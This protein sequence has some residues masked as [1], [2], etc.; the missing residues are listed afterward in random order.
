MNNVFCPNFANKK[1]KQEFEE[2][3]SIFGEDGAYLLWNQTKGNGLEL[4]PNG[5][6]SKLFKT[7]MKLFDG[8]RR[9]ALIAK[10]RVY[11]QEF[12]DWFG[13]WINDKENASKVVDKNGEPLI[14]QHG[15][16]DDKF[17]VFLPRYIRAGGGFWA[18]DTQNAEG[19]GDKR[20]YLFMNLRNPYNAEKLFDGKYGKGVYKKIL[21]Y[22]RANDRY[23]EHIRYLEDEMQGL[24]YALDF[25]P[26]SE[27]S[28]ISKQLSDLHAQRM[29]LQRPKRPNI[30]QQA[31]DDFR[32]A[33]YEAERDSQYSGLDNDPFYYRSRKTRLLHKKYGI[34]G[35]TSHGYYVVISSNQLKSATDNNGNFDPQDIDIR[36]NLNQ[37]SAENDVRNSIIEEINYYDKDSD[38]NE[39]AVHYFH[40]EGSKLYVTKGDARTL[41]EAVN[42]ATK[43]L[44]K[45]GFTENDFA[46]NSKTGE[47][48]F[49][50]TAED[51]YAKDS[52][53]TSLEARQH[54]TQIAEYLKQ[55]TGL[56]Y[57]L[58]KPSDLAKIGVN[59]SAN[60]FVKDGVVYLVDGRFTEQTTI[61]EFLHPF[62]NAI[63]RTNPELFQSLLNEA[64]Q[65]FPQLKS[66]IY[67]LYSNKK[68]F[69]TQDR[70]QE[71]V[72]QALSRVQQEEF[73]KGLGRNKLEQLIHK[74][75]N[76]IKQLFS[77]EVRA[78]D[79][80]P[81]TTLGQLARI[82]NSE[83]VSLKEDSKSDTQTRYNITP[84]QEQK[85]IVEKLRKLVHLRISA[86]RRRK[87]RDAMVEADFDMLEQQLIQL[88]DQLYNGNQA[89][90]QNAIDEIFKQVINDDKNRVALLEIAKQEVMQVKQHLD[91]IEA[92]R[93]QGNPETLLRVLRNVLDYYGN[94]M[95]AGVG[96]NTES[97]VLYDIFNSSQF[98][99]LPNYQVAL[100]EFQDIS[101][102]I[103]GI[104]GCR[105]KINSIIK[106]GI[107]EFLDKFIDQNMEAGDINLFKEN[108]HRWLDQ[109]MQTTDTAKVL[110]DP[111]SAQ[112]PVVRIFFHYIRQQQ[113]KVVDPT[114]EVMS[115]LR[116]QMDKLQSKRINITNYQRRFCET[117]SKGHTTGYFISEY[118]TGE[119]Y[120]V[121]REESKKIAQKYIDSGQAQYAIEDGKEVLQFAKWDD[122]KAYLAEVDKMKDKYGNRRYKAE[123]YIKRR[124][125][126][127]KDTMAT[128]DYL[129]S[130]INAIRSKVAEEVEFTSATGKKFKKKI[131]RL[132]KLSARDYQA[133]Q[134]L[135]Q[136]KAEFAMTYKRIVDVNG[137]TVD[138]VPKTGDELRMAQ[139][140]TKWN[141]VKS[142]NVGYRSNDDLGLQYL[143]M[144]EQQ[145][146]AQ[147]NEYKIACQRYINQ[148]QPTQDYYDELDALLDKHALPDD[149]QEKLYELSSIVKDIKKRASIKGRV[150]I[151]MSKLSENDFAVMKRVEQEISDIL[152][153]N[154]ITSLY[155]TQDPV[156]LN[157]MRNINQTP[158]VK[159]DGT[160]M[161]VKYRRPDGSEFTRT[162]S[163]FDYLTQGMTLSEIEAKYQYV[164]AK[165]RVVSL[166]VFQYSIPSD[167]NQIGD[168]IENFFAPEGNWVNDEYD[169]EW[170]ASVQPKEQFRNQDYDKLDAEEKKMLEMLKQ[171]MKEANKKYGI[172]GQVN[173]LLMPQIHAEASETIFGNGQWSN[174]KSL[175][176][177]IA[178][179]MRKKF[180]IGDETDD[181]NQKHEDP[182]R[183]K[184]GGVPVRYNQKMDDPEHISTDL[185]HTVTKYYEAASE[186]DV[187]TDA[188]NLAE[189]L[190]YC[191][192]DGRLTNIMDTELYGIKTVVDK[193]WQLTTLKQLEDWQRYNNGHLL[194][195]QFTFLRGI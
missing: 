43:H 37:R 51:R 130:K 82:I 107:D 27:S 39:K 155:H 156:A 99:N 108:T 30:P 19:Y 167:P 123:Y 169:E 42:R 91:A 1:V 46:I 177:G 173:E 62:V 131:Y 158:Y 83:G 74:F 185:L 3:V 23:D 61:E 5:A 35:E 21:E 18:E 190:N 106:Q 97:G 40:K 117:D 96:T 31:F 180:G 182:D 15:T 112:N 154:N 81:D 137:N 11:T 103:N 160:T 52:H 20:I 195:L 186:Y 121:V 175:N 143:K 9:K 187:L 55:V 58:I 45:K 183:Q 164:N 139:E 166:S 13:D 79:L 176:T 7:Y 152:V 136:R 114:Q 22:N 87:V 95:S 110:G 63:M 174:P 49:P 188:S 36:Y 32:E 119:Y 153:Q 133:L 33:F 120:R 94:A 127:S 64:A 189:L 144:C 76:A 41:Q 50:K 71:L 85:Q 28:D 124:E 172:D 193:Q 34:D 147:S 25:L 149:V 68:G 92:G 161:S 47:I 88:H 24:N 101:E 80:R 86:E 54:V 72:T 113:Q 140:M 162:M 73:K 118:N 105:N 65:A 168:K 84:A 67:H 135:E 132:E 53:P 59:T 150:Y 98:K 60:S 194:V 6:D 2:L 26:E 138:Y 12:K 90:P 89:V 78:K 141:A 38:G 115:R 14:V 77:N 93:V 170:S 163:A 126:L 66:E 17:S 179:A 44:I 191:A 165:G 116:K 102:I 192:Q 70:Q 148:N 16:F 8:D 142:R 157:S 56:D 171:A 181:F 104:D 122:E 178:Y 10:A 151:Q 109:H 128:E 29:H 129:N 145:Y 69:T 125:I 134:D 184:R 159:P 111:S 57:Q 75:W 146:G 4:A 100:Q 48:T